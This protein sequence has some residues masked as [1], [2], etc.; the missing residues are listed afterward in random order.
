MT[1]CLQHDVT[2]TK[3]PLD[4]HEIAMCNVSIKL[5]KRLTKFYEAWGTQ[6]RIFAVPMSAH[7]TLNFCSSDSLHL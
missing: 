6:F 2:T 4:S 7:M 1:I 5:Q 3:Q